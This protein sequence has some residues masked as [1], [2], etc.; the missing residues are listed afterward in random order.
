MMRD[1]NEQSEPLERHTLAEW[2]VRAN[3][4]QQDL[5]EVAGVHVSTISR[6]EST[7]AE[8]GAQTVV[9]ILDALSGALGYRLEAKQILWPTATRRRRRDKRGSPPGTRRGP[10]QPRPDGADA[11]DNDDDDGPDPKSVARAAA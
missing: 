3:M 7:N 6:I 1:D 8:P 9:D 4:T 10:R 2:R 11:D 5:A